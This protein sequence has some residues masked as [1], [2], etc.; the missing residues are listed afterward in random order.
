MLTKNSLLHKG[1]SVSIASITT[2]E[3]VS[4]YSMFSLQ[5]G[6]RFCFKQ[7][8]TYDDP[9][10]N[11]TISYP[12]GVVYEIQSF[13]KDFIRFYVVEKESKGCCNVELTI[14]T[15]VFQ[16]ASYVKIT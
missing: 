5:P 6:D 2:C 7:R 15:A 3:Q 11:W 9:Y 16:R 14:P 10:D 12:V 1:P 13:D 4:L 8:F